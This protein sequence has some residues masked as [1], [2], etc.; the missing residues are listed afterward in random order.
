MVQSETIDFE[1]RVRKPKGKRKSQKQNGEEYGRGVRG[2]LSIRRAE[3][4]KRA[5]ENAH[6]FIS[7]SYILS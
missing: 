1:K 2:V 7:N 5:L 6:E 4:G 3:V